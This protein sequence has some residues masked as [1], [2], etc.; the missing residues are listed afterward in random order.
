MAG[1]ILSRWS[2]CTASGTDLVSDPM[3]DEPLYET[4]VGVVKAEHPLMALKDGEQHT[5]STI[6]GIYIVIVM[7]LV[8]L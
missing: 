5:V 4:L 2:D 6:E 3:P 1:K 8:L 7:M